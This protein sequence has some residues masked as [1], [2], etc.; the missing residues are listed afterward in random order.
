MNKNVL[1]Y[2]KIYYEMTALNRFPVVIGEQEKGLFEFDC[3]TPLDI[4]GASLVKG[5]LWNYPENTVAL[6]K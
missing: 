5:F 2:T 3:S 4:K 1:Y 6:E